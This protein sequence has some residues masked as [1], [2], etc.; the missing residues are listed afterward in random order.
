[1]ESIISK[2]GADFICLY[3]R[4][5]LGRRGFKNKSIQVG[6]QLIT[7]EKKEY[8]EVMCCPGAAGLNIHAPEPG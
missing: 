5:M 7:D 6:G 4:A 8:D 2:I 3:T 1:M